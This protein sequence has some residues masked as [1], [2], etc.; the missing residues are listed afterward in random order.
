MEATPGTDPV[1]IVVEGKAD[2]GVGS[3]SLLLERHAGAP[4]VALA[5]I[6]QHSPLVL[7]ARQT[8]PL[9]NV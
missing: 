1:K 8:Q 3:S 7:V 4:V 2:F 6:F 9:Q 5:V